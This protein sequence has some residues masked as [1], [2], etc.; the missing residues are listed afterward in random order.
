LKTGQRSRLKLIKLEETQSCKSLAKRQ[1]FTQYLLVVPTLQ[2][3]N[4]SKGIVTQKLKTGKRSRIKLINL[5][6]TQA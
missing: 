3:Q 4:T 6:E 1:L 2:A 5:E